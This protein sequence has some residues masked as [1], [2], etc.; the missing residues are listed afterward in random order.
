MRR[1]RLLWR[2]EAR[3]WVASTVL[4]KQICTSLARSLV[5]EV[6]DEVTSR[7]PRTGVTSVVRPIEKFFCCVTCRAKATVLTWLDL[8]DA[9][10]G[11]FCAED[12]A[13]ALDNYA[14]DVGG[15]KK[16]VVVYTVRTADK[17]V[18][19]VAEEYQKKTATA[20]EEICVEDPFAQF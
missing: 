19:T 3:P 2:G 16:D 20:L 14:Q 12:L 17:D 5:T 1:G 15:R 7:D 4:M 11:P 13:E 9:I 8:G 18:L 10:V 6:K